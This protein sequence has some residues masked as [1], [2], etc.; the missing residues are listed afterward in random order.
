MQVEDFGPLERCAG[1]GN[2]GFCYIVGILKLTTAAVGNMECLA[3]SGGEH[4]LRWCRRDA[5]IA[6]WP[7]HGRWPQ[8]DAGDSGILPVDACSTLVGLLEDPVER[9]R[10]PGGGVL[11]HRTWLPSICGVIDGGR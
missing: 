11:D 1:T 2:E 9:A 3:D 6:S 4:R 7:I 10:M 5:L 8:P